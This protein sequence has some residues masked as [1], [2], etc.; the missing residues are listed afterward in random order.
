MKFSHKYPYPNA[1][2]IKYFWTLSY[3]DWGVFGYH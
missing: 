2:N 3:N 1:L